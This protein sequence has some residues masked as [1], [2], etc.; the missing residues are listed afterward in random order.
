MVEVR[1]G[2]KG[3]ILYGVTEEGIKIANNLTESYDKGN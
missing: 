1:I 3:D 2:E